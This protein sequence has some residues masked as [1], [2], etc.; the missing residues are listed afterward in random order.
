MI[1]EDVLRGVLETYRDGLV[2]PENVE[3][4]EVRCLL[5]ELHNRLY[6]D[7]LNVANLRSWSGLLDHNVSSRF[8]RQMG[9]SVHSY[10]EI[11]RVE[12][13]ARA[14]E[15]PLAFS[16]FSIAMEVGYTS[17]ELFSRVFKRHFG[18]SPSRFRSKGGTS[19][20]A[21]A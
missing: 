17:P 5:H 18:C 14:L 3:S 16:I 15:H 9:L 10:I 20:K 1:A 21:A 7:E 8:K 2:I 13:A 11:K 19:S 6:D 4:V 12:A